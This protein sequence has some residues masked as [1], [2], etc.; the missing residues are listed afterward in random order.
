M[1]R[2]EDDALKLAAGGSGFARAFF[3]AAACAPLVSH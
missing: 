3:N 2:R 1:R